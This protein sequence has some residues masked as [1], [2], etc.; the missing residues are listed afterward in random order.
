MMWIGPMMLYKHYVYGLFINTCASGTC[1]MGL[2]D[3]KH[4]FVQQVCVLF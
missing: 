3:I 1:V 4:Y 2:T